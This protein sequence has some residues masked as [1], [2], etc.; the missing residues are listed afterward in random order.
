M[1]IQK[2]AIVD[3]TVQKRMYK[4]WSEEM[5]RARIVLILCCYLNLCLFCVFGFV[6]IFYHSQHDCDENQLSDLLL[7]NV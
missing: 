2:E 3:N 1:Q 6:Y 7:Y 5:K 4:K